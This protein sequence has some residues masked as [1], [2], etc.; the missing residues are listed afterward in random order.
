MNGSTA[1]RRDGPMPR[2]GSVALVN[3]RL[4]GAAM[5]AG[6][7]AIVAALGASR[8]EQPFHGDQAF[9]TVGA[10]KLAHGAV[11]YRDFWDFKQPGIY[12]FYEA[13]GR[14]FDFS[15]RGVHL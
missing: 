11:L 5:T 10:Q 13:A 3:P 2:G 8:L 12:W 7:L 9:F 15:E 14:L 6:A 4:L 1:I